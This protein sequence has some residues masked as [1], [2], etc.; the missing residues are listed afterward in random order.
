MR[1]AKNNKFCPK[2]MRINRGVDK[3]F[4]QDDLSCRIETFENESISL[5]LKTIPQMSYLASTK[6]R[7]NKLTEIQ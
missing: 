3:S 4:L 1:D 2:R 6:I 7:N 5:Q